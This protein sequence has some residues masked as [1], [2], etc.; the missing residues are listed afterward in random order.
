MV[1]ISRLNSCT[2]ACESLPKTPLLPT[3]EKRGGPE[4]QTAVAEGIFS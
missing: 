1:P 2:K 4:R 3:A